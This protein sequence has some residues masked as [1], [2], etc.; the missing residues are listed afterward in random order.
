MEE[1]AIPFL[2]VCA[3]MVGWW[4]GGLVSAYWFAVEAE[5]GG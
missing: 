2:E 1:T 3:D 4:D 5:V